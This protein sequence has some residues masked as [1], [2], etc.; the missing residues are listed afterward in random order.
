MNTEKFSIFIV[1]A[2]TKFQRYV[3]DY[4]AEIFQTLK[5]KY[6]EFMMNSYILHHSIFVLK[7]S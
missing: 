7:Q 5:Q 3:C 6:P 2:G 4:Q 1:C